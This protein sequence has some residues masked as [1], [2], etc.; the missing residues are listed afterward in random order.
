MIFMESAALLVIHRPRLHTARPDA[1]QAAVRAMPAVKLLESGVMARENRR[2]L[3]SSIG[4]SE[5]KNQWLTS[6]DVNS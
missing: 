6:I 1:E 5:E 2:D 4:S 3:R